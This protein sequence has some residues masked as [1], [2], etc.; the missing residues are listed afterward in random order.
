MS[1]RLFLDDIRNP[2]DVKWIQLPLA[3][4]VIVR[5]YEDC[6]KVIEQR[7]LPEFITFDHDLADVHYEIFAKFL[8]GAASYDELYAN[9]KEKTG[10]HCAKW[11]VDYCLDNDKKLPTFVV[12]SMNSV[13]SQ[14]ITSLL[15][16]FKKFQATQ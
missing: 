9:C 8:K 13:G 5:K 11:L 15:N 14:N 7:G 10:Y 2:A 1:Y 6:V 16:N 4:W 3:P 12:H